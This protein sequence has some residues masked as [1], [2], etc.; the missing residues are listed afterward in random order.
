LP[1]TRERCRR[2]GV[3]TALPRADQDSR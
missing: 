3:W 1:G 2:I